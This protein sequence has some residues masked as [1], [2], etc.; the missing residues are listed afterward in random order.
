MKRFAYIGLIMFVASC[1]YFYA[2][3]ERLLVRPVHEEIIEVQPGQSATTVFE[4]SNLTSS[5]QD[6][7]IHVQLPEDWRL[8]TREFPFQMKSGKSEIKLLGFKVPGNVPAGEYPI[9]VRLHNR[10]FPE[11]DDFYK[12]RVVVKSIS[13][14][15]LQVLSGPDYIQ[16]GES[17][18]VFFMIHNQSNQ[19]E[20]ICIEPR[21]CKYTGEN[22]IKLASGEIYKFLV[23]ASTDAASK[24]LIQKNVEVTASIQGNENVKSRAIHRLD[25]V[26]REGVKYDP[27]HRLPI[28]G[29]LYYISDDR[30]GT[31]ESGHQFDI[32]GKGSLDA[33]KNHRVE[34]QLRGPNR[35]HLSVLGRYDE[36]YAIYETDRFGVTLGDR[37]LMMTELTDPSRYG[38]GISGYYRHHRTKISC[39]YQRPRFYRQIHEE[40]AVRVENQSSR[41]VLLGLNLLNKTHLG[42][43]AHIFSLNSLYHKNDTEIETEFGYS[44]A[45]GRNSIS[46]RMVLSSKYGPVRAFFR[47]L[48]AGPHYAGYYTN[49]RYVTGNFSYQLIQTLSLQVNVRQDVQNAALD[50]LF[51][52]APMTRSWQTGLYWSISPHTRM[53]TY[54][55]QRER[56]DR[57][58]DKKFDYK[59]N[60]MQLGFWKKMWHL[61][62]TLNGEFGQTYNHL[63][64]FEG[65]KS[66]YF[67]T[68]ATLYYDPSR[69]FN[70]QLHLSYQ[71]S[72]RYSRDRQHHTILGMTSFFQVLKK[73]RLFLQYQNSHAIEEY[74]RDRNLFEIRLTQFI[75]SMHE[76]DLK[77]RY[78]LLK[79]CVDKKE[80][81][82]MAGYRLNL[83]VPVQKVS[84]VGTVKGQ[85]YNDGVEKVSGIYLRLNGCTAVTNDK[86]V[87]N[88]PSV[89]PG[90][91]Y[92]IVDKSTIGLHDIPTVPTPIKVNILPDQE[93]QIDFAVTRAANLFGRVELK[94]NADAHAKLL[95]T[96]D[97]IGH[98]IIEMKMGR[99]VYR[100]LTDM[101]GEFGFY[102]LR[103]GTWTMIVYRNGMPK[104][105]VIVQK[106]YIHDLKPGD[107]K[108]VVVLV[109]KKERKIKFI[110]DWSDVVVD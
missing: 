67:K 49:T 103:P 4:I 12:F 107:R 59:E 85:I 73:T 101:N 40:K 18:E 77:C 38:R 102:D 71:E 14:L 11:L 89:K 60:T 78:S 79:N 35:Y 45:D 5:V 47:Y 37:T 22:N 16:A 21:R 3:Q 65:I 62:F 43:Q 2:A 72:N 31:V 8:I 68:M 109:K 64:A 15:S 110:Q 90:T 53:K 7:E 30:S 10:Q 26:P 69:R 97:K 98:V 106:Q 80:F 88:F 95:D 24:Q 39:F 84:H 61:N 32:S 63:P 51:Y 6:L 48:H 66:S 9:Q 42:D 86:G 1:S 36:Y 57:K 46:Y 52:H 75:R 99:E 27:Y 74:Y 70:M 94:E 76:F 55:R 58:P 92:L 19:P 83:G 41:H 50:T 91:Y 20:I 28:S 108:E 93:Q 104:Q 25:I 33:E 87:Y 96:G 81:A 82:F 105:F 56:I 23:T 54:V 34:F 100:R 29:S 17:I 44:R 13:K